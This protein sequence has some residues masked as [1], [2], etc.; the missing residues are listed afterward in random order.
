MSSAEQRLWKR[1]RAL[2]L[3]KELGN[4]SEAC[5]RLGMGRTQF[6]EF[7][8]RYQA[9]GLA[10]LVNRPPIHKSH[11]Q[12]TP[13]SVVRQ[14]LDL[15][16]AH[17]AHGCH[18]LSARLL[19]ETGV[20]VSGG[21]IQ[22]IL[23]R[24]GMGTSTE[25]LLKLE[26]KVS[27]GQVQPSQEQL[28]ALEK[29][30]PC[31]LERSQESSAPGELLCQE[32]LYIGTFEGM[33]KVYLQTVVDSYGS[34]AFGYLH[35]GR[36]P[37][38]AVAILHN[39]VLPLY[40]A[41]GM[42]VK[43]ILTHNGGAYCGSSTHPYEFYLRLN[44]IGHKKGK[45]R[46][47]QIHGFM[48]VKVRFSKPPGFLQR[49]HRTIVDEFIRR[50]CRTK[51]YPHLDALQKDLDRWLY[52]YNFRRPHQGYPNWGKRPVD[53][54]LPFE[55]P[56]LKTLADKNPVRILTLEKLTELLDQIKRDPSLKEQLAIQTSA[57]H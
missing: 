49:F 10:G 34:F 40:E 54:V 26:E 16:L 36:S 39:Q 52:Y 23:A 7:K 31:Y 9:D 48:E 45:L 1:L 57:V 33:G 11:P 20:R 25:R 15:A 44:N 38:H 29:F 6:Y 8:R 50:D 19:Q 18:L 4:D 30:N 37:E 35:T 5:R 51:V 47:F 27:G 43:A 14:I 12:T 32:T 3:A 46:F 17:P 21:T 41:W 2:E 24:H 22:K 42:D 28:A 56:G 53:T 55:K 13:P